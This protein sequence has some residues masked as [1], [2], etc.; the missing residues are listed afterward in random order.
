M[1]LIDFGLPVDRDDDNDLAN[2]HDPVLKKL[3]NSP[4]NG[5]LKWK[6]KGHELD[7]KHNGRKNFEFYKPRMEVVKTFDAPPVHRHIHGT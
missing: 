3:Q 6:Y 5:R 7:T 4:I 1:C 2:G